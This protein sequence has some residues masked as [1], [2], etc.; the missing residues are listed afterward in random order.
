MQISVNW[1]KD[2]VSIEATAQE[3]ADKLSVSG[4]EVEHLETWET[5]KGGLKGFVIGHVVDC[6][7]HPNADKLSITK[8][9]IGV[10]D[11]QPIVC[12]APNVAAGQKVVV[13]TV[14]TEVTV[15]GKG[16]F[17][18]G[19]AKIRGEISRGM[20]CAED[21][22]GLGT[23]HDGILVLAADAPIGQLASEYFNVISDEVME[24]GLTAN[25]GDAASH[26]GVARDVAALFGVGVLSP[27]IPARPLS[28]GDYEI[29]IANP[30]SCS[31]YIGLSVGEVSTSTSPEFM[32]NRLRA[33]GIEPKNLVVD[34]TNYVLH[35]LGQPIH[36]FDADKIHGKKI[37]IR[38]AEKGEKLTTLDKIERECIGGEL[39]IADDKGLIAFAG[40]MGGLETAVSESTTN[41]LIESAH[42]HPGLVRKTAK[43]QNLNTDASFRFERSTDINMCRKAAIWA[44]DLI[45]QNGSGKIS[46]LNQ[47]LVEDYKI[48]TVLLNL[49]KLN[50]FAGT[51]IPANRSI[52]ILQELGFEVEKNG[53]T[54]K[55]MIPSWRNDVHETVDLYEEIMRIYGYDNIP[56]SGK[57]SATLPVF[58]GFNLRKT[59]NSARNFFISNGFYEANNNSLTSAEYYTEEEQLNLVE[60]TNPL[61]SDLQFMRGNLMHGLMQ[62]AAYN[63]NR[64]TENI[65]F[66]EF[67]NCYK[68][69]DEKHLESRQLGVLVGGMQTEESWEQKMIPM[70]FYYVKRIV[71][72]M[73]KSAGFAGSSDA[74]Y[75]IEKVPVATLKMHDL[76]ADFWYAEVDWNAVLMQIHPEGFKVLNPPKFPWMRRDLSLVVDK[77]VTFKEINSI[78]QKQKIELLKSTRV[79]DV[80]EGKPLDA[81]KKAVAIAFY[82][83]NPETTLTDIDAEVAMSQLMKAFETGVGAM[84]RR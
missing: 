50:A 1:L 29:E 26:L 79:F 36:A 78:I 47:C 41:I 45:T 58:E 76:N 16:S 75:H 5:I 28:T 33:I 9:D 66:F 54:Y 53:D 17:T 61:S 71:E 34:T 44:A 59:E 20:I 18:I 8:V 67:G 30:E 24:I 49:D 51:Q 15:P 14:G 63:R 25:R 81:G 69:L 62:N 70:D 13:A 56:M 57:M 83:G 55:V 2:F 68:L 4:L 80:F 40:V 65:R 39:V 21:E 46:G 73:L 35:A 6:E 31:L 72:N 19:E 27:D 37:Q 60:I 43:A 64:K 52:E 74:V 42:F 82:L 22:M 12:G 38:Q 32:Q 7:K 77:S 10:G 3:M 84:I 23:S 11:L 48:R